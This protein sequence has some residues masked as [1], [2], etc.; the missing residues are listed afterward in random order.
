M[1]T[2]VGMLNDQTN[3]DGHYEDNVDN[4]QTA[5]NW[6]RPENNG[7]SSVWNAG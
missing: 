6:G 3:S 7:F 2:K 5:M 4:W 1:V